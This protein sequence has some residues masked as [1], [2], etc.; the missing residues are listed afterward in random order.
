MS[1]VK[2]T[3]PNDPVKAVRT[4]IHGLILTTH[5]GLTKRE[6]FAAMAMQ[7]MLAAHDDRY[8]RTQG[9]TNGEAL[10]ECAIAQADY[11]IVALNKDTKE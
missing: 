9:K 7:G 6:Y 4:K 2:K 10:A 11:L 3:K 5:N 8:E 1:E